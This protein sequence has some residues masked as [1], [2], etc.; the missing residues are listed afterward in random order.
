MTRQ[1]LL[2]LIAN[3]ALDYTSDVLSYSRVY[4]CTYYN[5]TPGAVPWS[6]DEDFY[7]WFTG[8]D[9]R[10]RNPIAADNKIKSIIKDIKLT[11]VQQLLDEIKRDF[12]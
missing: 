1:E 7:V 10:V 8:I 11:K 12:E 2:D 6:D 9:V 5:S 3:N 4:V